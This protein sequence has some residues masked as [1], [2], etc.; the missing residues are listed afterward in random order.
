MLPWNS[1]AT[2]RDRCALAEATGGSNTAT[3]AINKP[4]GL[5]AA[6]SSSGYTKRLSEMPC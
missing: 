5:A 4:S 1:L 6:C 2:A 3:I